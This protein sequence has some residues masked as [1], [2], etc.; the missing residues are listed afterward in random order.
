VNSN[1]LAD[2]EPDPDT[3]M[4]VLCRDVK[5]FNV[6]YFDGTDWQSSWDSTATTPANMIPVAVR[7]TLEL[8]PPGGKTDRGD[9]KRIVKVVSLACYVDLTTANTA[10]GTG[11]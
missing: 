3:E 10:T 8:Y 7:I 4:E 9:F 5:G 11:N 2:Q 6:E 1:L